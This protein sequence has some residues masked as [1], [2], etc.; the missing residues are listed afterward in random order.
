MFFQIAAKSMNQIKISD[1]LNN[2]D[3]CILSTCFHVHNVSVLNV[4]VLNDFLNCSQKIMKYIFVGVIFIIVAWTE[5]RRFYNKRTNNCRTLMGRVKHYLETQ[6]CNSTDPHQQW[7]WAPNST[8]QNSATKLFIVGVA[9]TYEHDAYLEMG[10]CNATEPTQEWMTYKAKNPRYK[11][12]I[13]NMG[14]K[15]ECLTEH[16]FGDVSLLGCHFTSPSQWV[17]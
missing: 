17:Q 13:K 3:K 8:I 9:A 14:M 1:F 5:G 7:D 15:K 10:P 12:L 16:N 11:D 6:P 4:S 2:D